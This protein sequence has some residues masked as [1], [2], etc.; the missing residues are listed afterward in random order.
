[1][2]TTEIETDGRDIWNIE[3]AKLVNPKQGERKGK[4]KVTLKYGLFKINVLQHD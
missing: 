3:T 1:M 2:G 4:M